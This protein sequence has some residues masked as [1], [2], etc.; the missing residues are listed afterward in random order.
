[1]KHGNPIA[2]FYLDAYSRPAEKRGGAWMDACINRSK[3]TENG[4]TTIR[5]PVAYLMCNQTPPVDG[6]PSLMTFYEVETLFHEFGHGL[7]HMLTKV[8][9]T[10]AAGINNVEWDAVELPSQ[11]ME[12]WCYERPTLFGMAKHYRNWRTSTRALLP[13]TAGST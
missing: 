11:F 3:I 10:G 7:H 5:L 8:D 9:Y 1:M 4:V 6:K 12:N 2:Y 13:K